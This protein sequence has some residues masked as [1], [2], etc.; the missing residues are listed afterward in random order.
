[1]SGAVVKI[2]FNAVVAQMVNPDQDTR[3]IASEILSYKV[4]GSEHMKSFASK[5]W[6]GYSS[7]YK[8]SS[9]SFPAGFVRY[10][11]RKLEKRGCR[12]VL[13][14]TAP[15]VAPLGPEQPVVDS[16]PFTEKY[17]YQFETVDRLVNLGAMIAQVATGGGKSRIFKIAC[18]RI[19]RPTLFLTTRKTLMYQMA[20]QMKDQGRELGIMGDGE[21]TPTET[22]VNFAIVD[23]LATRLQK[24]SLEEEIGVI[25]ERISSEIE[26]VTGKI[27]EK[28]GMNISDNMLKH[29]PKQV[30]EKV[31]AYRKA[32]EDK[33]W[34]KH[35][36]SEIAKQAQAK[37]KIKESRRQD[38]IKILRKMEFVALEEAHEVSAT[39]FYDIMN[40]CR[41]ADYRL[42]LTA[43][44]FMK[45]DQEANMRL[46]AVTGPIGIR[47]S[48]KQLIDLGILAKPYFYY[49]EPENPKGLFRGSGWQKAYKVGIVESAPRNNFII[50]ETVRAAS[51]GLP[52][53]T[54]VQQTAH[55]RLLKKMLN[56]AGVKTEFI[57]GECKQ[58][59]R[60]K[61]LNKL[62]DGEIQCLIGSTIL[63]VGVDVPAVGVVV[64]AGG[65]KAEVSLRQRIGRGLRAKTTMP[66]ICF[67]F[68]F[69]DR[70]NNHLSKHSKMRRAV[71]AETPGFA[72]NVQT[73]LFQ[74]EKFGLKKLE[75]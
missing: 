40:Q 6:D 58:A 52:V 9:N 66:N 63:D 3:L 65:G 12:V 64:L 68:D 8:M 62:K 44:P 31:A 15:R 74:Y 43:T 51:Y 34:A 16:F 22:G 32:I 20:A 67:V 39:G 69:N 73:N 55:G 7:L 33:M 37:L 5:S 53:M 54:L 46:M 75:K 4:A 48:E 59:T 1:M 50:K 21:W 24:P 57:S 26:A 14:R 41:A 71:V 36:R 11:K 56:E 70:H 45:D 17:S 42:A 25:V 18:A 27:L 13:K 72:E 60:Q 38:V 2:H 49:F 29:A 19:N 35:P 47:I 30:Q 10:L 23:T 28:K 61:A